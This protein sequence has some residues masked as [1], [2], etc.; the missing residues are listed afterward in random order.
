M[1]PEEFKKFKEKYNLNVEMGIDYSNN[2][3]YFP[4]KIYESTLSTAIAICNCTVYETHLSD[5]SLRFFTKVLV[6]ETYEEAC[7]VMDTDF[8]PKIKL[9][10]MYDRL[11][12]L[13][14]ILTL[15]E[16]KTVATNYELY[17]ITP[18]EAYNTGIM[19][20]WSTNIVFKET[21]KDSSGVLVKDMSVED[22]YAQRRINNYI[23]KQVKISNKLKKIKEDF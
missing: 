21:V 19:C 4:S 3:F 17:K 15:D 13:E 22:Y 10:K 9:R 12:K 18:E 11:K 16:F 5:I 20:S 7:E 6:T 23:E 8:L 2:Y 1:T 14:A